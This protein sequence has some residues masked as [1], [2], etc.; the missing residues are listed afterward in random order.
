MKESN[1]LIISIIIIIIIILMVGMIC[2]NNNTC[3]QNNFDDSY[4]KTCSSIPGCQIILDELSTSAWWYDRCISLPFNCTHNDDNI[5]TELTY[6]QNMV[7][8]ANYCLHGVE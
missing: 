1:G 5:N 2:Y 4:Y 8:S 6:C 3:N 7:H